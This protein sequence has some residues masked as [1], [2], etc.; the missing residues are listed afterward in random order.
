MTNV[1]SALRGPKRRLLNDGH[2]HATRSLRRSYYDERTPDAAVRPTV[3]HNALGTFLPTSAGVSHRQAT[4]CTLAWFHQPT[5]LYVH[6]AACRLALKDWL[7][8]PVF[9]IHSRCQYIARHSGLQCG[10]LM[11]RFAHHANSCCNALLVARHHCIRD[12][13]LRGVVPSPWMAFGS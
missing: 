9:A 5:G 10:K 13:L 6:N 1:E 2:P 12:L 4:A 3:S 11:D 8:L 7:S